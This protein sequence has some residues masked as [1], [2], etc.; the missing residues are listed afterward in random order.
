MDTLVHLV[1]VISSRDRV[2]KIK[3]VLLVTLDVIHQQNNLMYMKRWLH[4]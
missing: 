2:I 1:L 3:L 4:F